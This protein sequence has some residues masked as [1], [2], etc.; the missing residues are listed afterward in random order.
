VLDDGLYRSF[1]EPQR[2]LGAQAS[3]SRM[4]PPDHGVAT[5][6]LADDART[7]TPLPTAD[8]RMVTP[9]SA[10]DARTATPPPGADAGAQGT[11]G[12]I[13][14][15]N[16]PPVI[17]VDPISAIPIGTDENLVKDQAQN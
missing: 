5:Q 17:D 11:I 1:V 4:R 10:V 2:D 14:A 12:D 8:S 3:P 16:S 6:T 13:G 9:P 15:S 7:V